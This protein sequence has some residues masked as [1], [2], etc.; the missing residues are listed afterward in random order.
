LGYSHFDL[1]EL[2]DFQLL[3]QIWASIN[4]LQEDIFTPNTVSNTSHDGENQLTVTVENAGS[5]YL[6]IPT[7]SSYTS[8]KVTGA[9]REREIRYD[10]ASEVYYIGELDH[11]ESLDISFAAKDGNFDLN[12]ISCYTENKNIIFQNS[13]LVNQQNL[14]IE[15]KNS[16]QLVM[17]YS[18]KSSSIATTIPYDEGWTVYDNGKKLTIEKNWNNF[19]AFQLDDADEHN[20][21]LVYRPTGFGIGSKITIFSIVLLILF[22]ILNLNTIKNRLRKKRA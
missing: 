1:D 4:G 22:E 3:N 21:E 14:S 16:S 6:L 11:G 17:S 9:R 20:I 19:L 7:R 2:N 13:Q 18:G 8:F 10:D 5:L 15:E 12:S